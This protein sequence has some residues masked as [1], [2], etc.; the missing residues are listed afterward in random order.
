MST[1]SREDGPTTIGS[2]LR[3]TGVTIGPFD[4]SSL[5]NEEWVEGSRIEHFHGPNQ[6]VPS[7]A[8]ITGMNLLIRNI[9]L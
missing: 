8:A 2:G 7:A 6:F 5:I 1:D 3:T 9:I 4:L